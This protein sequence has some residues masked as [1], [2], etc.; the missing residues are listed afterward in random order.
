MYN[1]IE[2]CKLVLLSQNKNDFDAF[3]LTFKSTE[4]IRSV[5]YDDD[6]I[7][8]FFTLGANRRSSLGPAE[9]DLDFFT[10]LINS[11]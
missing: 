2:N 3:L 10:Y 9:S 4:V 6:F 5:F 7:E 11:H 8:T 1:V